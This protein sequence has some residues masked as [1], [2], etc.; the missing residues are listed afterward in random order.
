MLRISSVQEKHGQGTRGNL[1]G[2]CAK[3]FGSVALSQPM[4]APRVRGGHDLQLV[5]ALPEREVVGRRIS[6]KVVESVADLAGHY[7]LSRCP[8]HR[9]TCLG[10]GP[11][12]PATQ[13]ARGSPTVMTH[14]LR[15]FVRVSRW[16]E[17]LRSTGSDMIAILLFQGQALLGLTTPQLALPPPH[18]EILKPR[19]WLEIALRKSG[20]QPA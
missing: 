10:F 13:A 1:N 5:G 6:E 14:P 17:T 20:S 7:R 12:K 11:A 3:G 15:H 16:L 9:P 18:K 2:L 19:L 4:A 8:G